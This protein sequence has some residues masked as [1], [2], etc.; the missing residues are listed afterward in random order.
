MKYVRYLQNAF[1][2]RKNVDIRQWDIN[3]SPPESWEKIESI[4]CSNVLEHVDDDAQAIR[5]MKAI[6]RPGGRIVLVAPAGDWLYG[7]LDGALEHRRRYSKQKIISLLSESGFA[8]ETVFSMNKLGVLGWW[9]NGKVFRRKTLGKVQLKLFNALVPMIR[10]L[11]PMLPW[12]GLSLV[13]VGV[14]P[15][16]TNIDQNRLQR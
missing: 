3:R 12:M 1:G 11:D 13:V 5:N 10:L 14:I 4:L 8:V 16:E 6:L 9:L 15:S 7:S 2:G